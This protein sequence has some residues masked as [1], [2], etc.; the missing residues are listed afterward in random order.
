MLTILIF[1]LLHVGTPGFTAT[2]GWDPVTGMYHRHRMP[3]FPELTVAY[4]CWHTEPDET[5]GALAHITVSHRLVCEYGTLVDGKSES[6]AE[7]LKT[8]AQ[9]FSRFEI[10]I[11]IALLNESYDLEWILNA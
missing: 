6:E 11:P 1:P 3:G 10:C 2:E 4:R 7:R 5:I 9:F 8:A